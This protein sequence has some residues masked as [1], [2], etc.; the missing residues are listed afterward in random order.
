M[1][2]SE[3]ASFKTSFLFASA[4]I[5]IKQLSL[6]KIHY[7]VI[8][9]FVSLFGFPLCLILSVVAVETDYDPKN[10]ADI[11]EPDFIWDCSFALISAVT[12]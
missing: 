7:S 2:Y 6:L 9:L 4:S 11:Y 12:G 5:L 1:T 8:N 10:L 3:S